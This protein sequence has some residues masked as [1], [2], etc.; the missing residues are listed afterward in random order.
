M[1]L[2]TILSGLFL[3]FCERE[4]LH[5]NGAEELQLKSAN[6]DTLLINYGETINLQDGKSW[7]K[8]VDVEDSRC[9]NNVVC[10]WEG[11]AKAQFIYYDGESEKSFYLNTQGSQQ[12]LSESVISDLYFSL[13]S[14]DPYPDGSNVPG[15]GYSARIYIQY[16]NKLNGI[17]SEISGIVRDY[18]GLDGC[19]WIIEIEGGNKLE[20]ALILPNIQFYD[21]QEVTVWYK[22][23]EGMSSTCMVG[24]IAKIYKIESVSCPSF[25]NLP[26]GGLLDDYPSD[27]IAM[28]TAYLED[29]ILYVSIGHSGGCAEHVYQLLMFPLTCATPPLPKP[30]FWLSHDAGGDMCEAYLRDTLCFNISALREYYKKGTEIEIKTI[31]GNRSITL[32]F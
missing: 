11:N 30:V 5:D 21:G 28:D 8:F 25:T 6:G 10:F 26:L 9:P 24:Q 7:V 1:F 18:T 2:F 32:G 27:D 13:V 4:K 20:P 3:V 12:M 17:K 31:T 14:I 23:M 19:G 16:L 22:E 29:N 15:E